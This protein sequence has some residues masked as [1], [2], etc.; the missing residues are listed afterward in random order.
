MPDDEIDIGVYRGE[1]IG[2]TVRVELHVAVDLHEELR[3]NLLGPMI[4]RAMEGR[5]LAA[6][7][8]R[9]GGLESLMRDALDRE[10]DV[11]VVERGNHCGDRAAR[12]PSA[13]ALVPS[14][15]MPGRLAREEERPV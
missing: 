5:D 7:T 2:E 13:I 15:L 8:H 9:L 10:V 11:Q 1:E 12:H 3:T 14:R 6:D 4:Q